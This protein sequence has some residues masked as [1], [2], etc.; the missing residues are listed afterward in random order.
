MAQRIIKQ[1][2]ARA[3]SVRQFVFS[4]C[5]GGDH[6][7]VQQTTWVDLTADPSAVSLNASAKTESQTQDIDVAQLEKKSFENGY[8]EGKKSGI[9]F[10]ER[11]I[12]AA[13]KRLGDSILEIGRLR[14]SLYAQVECE[15]VKLAVAVARKIV[16]REIQADP[17][18]IQALV[19]VALGHVTEK[20]AVTIHLNPIDH[21]YLLEQGS[22][23][24]E[25][26]GH[27]IS[28]VADK[29]IERGGCLIRTECGDV[30]ARIEEKFREVENTFYEGLK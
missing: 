4:D 17:H 16:H 7:R 26:G 19:R 9:E 3:S 22:E 18:V 30:D 14:S 21:N 12:D 23:F 28:L 15:V 2:T 5:L 27:D 24:S 20:S 8:A 13:T 1:G 10:G 11:T 29:S 6:P 25:N